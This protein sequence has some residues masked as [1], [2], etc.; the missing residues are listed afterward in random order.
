MLCLLAVLVFVVCWLSLYVRYV[1]VTG[2]NYVRRVLCVIC[3]VL[4][5]MLEELRVM[6]NGR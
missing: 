6:P 3:I 2:Y 4:S 5:G 1:E